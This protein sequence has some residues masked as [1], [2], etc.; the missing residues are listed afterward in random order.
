LRRTPETGFTLIE[1]LAVCLIIGILALIALPRMGDSRG[2][3][4]KASMIA[5]LHNLLTA[6]EGYFASNGS[7]SSNLA[8]LNVDPPL[9]NTV[10]INEATTTGWSATAGNP[11]ISMQCY[12]FSGNATPIG[13]ATTAGVT[14][15]S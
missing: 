14:S 15:C 13:S 7:Y 5:D 9:S 3:A 11:S 10:T 2:R 8:F 4:V 6:E 1:I 12:L